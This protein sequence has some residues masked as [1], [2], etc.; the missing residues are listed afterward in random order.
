MRRHRA[1][2]GGA[3]LRPRHSAK[4]DICT[5]QNQG[6]EVFESSGR[7][8]GEALGGFPKVLMFFERFWEVLGVSARVWRDFMKV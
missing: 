4:I 8:Q 5:N 3:K 6:L 1:Q 7:G 2:R